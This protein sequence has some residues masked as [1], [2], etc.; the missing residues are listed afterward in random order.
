MLLAQVGFL[1]ALSGSGSP[2]RQLD[3]I[4]ALGKSGKLSAVPELYRVMIG[5][6]VELRLSA[7]KAI[8]QICR[9]TARDAA[10]LDKRRA[11]PFVTPA[12]NPTQLSSNLKRFLYLNPAILVKYE[13]SPWTDKKGNQTKIESQSA[14]FGWKDFEDTS[15]EWSWVC[16]IVVIDQAARIQFDRICH[17]NPEAVLNLLKTPSFPYKT[18][19][20]R[21]MGQCPPPYESTLTLLS[22]SE[23]SS[24]RIAV[25]DA[26]PEN[27]SRSFVDALVAAVHDKS[28]AVRYK[29]LVRVQDVAPEQANE[30]LSI[31]A[32]DPN[33]WIREEAKRE[34]TDT[35]F[36]PSLQFGKTKD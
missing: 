20:I 24:V 11:G 4:A 31:L 26:F 16:G 15:E 6:V 19:L 3:H 10:A 33:K 21:T 1:V 5:P 36:R 9:T 22:K 29:V 12:E 34:L 17:A 23:P 28:A 8:R 32:Q 35:G 18:F 13:N 14:Y 27:G 7:A 30:I 25:L 2:K